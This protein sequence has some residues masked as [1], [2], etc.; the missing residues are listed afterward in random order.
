VV[1]TVHESQVLDRGRIPLTTH[2]VRLDLIVRPDRD[3]EGARSWGRAHRRGVQW[4]ELSEEKI[5]AIPLL[6]RLRPH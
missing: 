4:D 5:A 1:T 6:Q 3:S 2:D